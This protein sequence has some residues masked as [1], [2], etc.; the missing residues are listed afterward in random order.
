M[1]KTLLVGISFSGVSLVTG[2]VMCSDFLCAVVI[3]NLPQCYHNFPRPV[4]P[5]NISY[6]T[7]PL[8]GQTSNVYIFSH[9]NNLLLCLSCPSMFYY[10]LFLYPPKM[11]VQ[12]V[13]FYLLIPPDLYSADPLLSQ[14]CSICSFAHFGLF[15][16][17]QLVFV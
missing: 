10:V 3:N 14:P 6:L 15:L 9:R 13:K 2:A 11:L 8:P 1:A 12:L 7:S 5:Y 16:I 4:L 17:V